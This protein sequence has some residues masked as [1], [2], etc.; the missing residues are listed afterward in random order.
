MG[1]LAG[2]VAHDLN[3]MLGPL[4]GYPELILMKLP[5]DSPVRK[6]VE[7]VG[8][9][10]KDAA[11]VIQDL[12]TLARRGRYEM[13]PTD[14]NEVVRSYLDSPSCAQLRQRCPN[15][16]VEISLSESLPGILGSSVH[17]SKVVMNLVV[18]AFDAMPQGGSLNIETVCEELQRLRSGHDKITPDTFV[19][20]KVRD[21][22]M[23]IA[24]EDLTKIFEP[25]YSKKRM[26]TSGSGLGLSVVYGVIKDHG[27]YYDILSETGKGTEFILYF[28]VSEDVQATSRQRSVIDDSAEQR[29]LALEMLRSL[30]YEV[31]A[32]VNG[33]EAVRHLDEHRVDLILLDMIMEPDMDGLDTYTEIVRLHPGQRAIIVSGFAATDRVEQAQQLGAGAYVRKPYTRAAIAAAV[34]E[35]LDKTPSLASQTS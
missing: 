14:L 6:Q 32:A 19:V 35:E 23:G 1:I 15:V 22:G 13:Q 10:A 11:D 12:L 8:T 5:K 28:P 2:G 18:N 26:G 27:G 3:N 7:R 9:A 31:S 17:L 21:T 4:V 30:G 24:A 33:T 34:R 29:E 25:Y 16:S 20:L